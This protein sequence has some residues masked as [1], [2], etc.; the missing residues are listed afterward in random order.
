MPTH[1]FTIVLNRRPA[2]EELDRL[3]DQGLDDA[4]FGVER[5]VSIVEFD[6]DAGSS[7]RNRDRGRRRHP[8]P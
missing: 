3:V 8:K 4:T 7:R 2:D 6:R 1:T 5:G